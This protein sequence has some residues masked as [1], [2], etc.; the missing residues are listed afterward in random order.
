MSTSMACRT[1]PGVP[2]ERTRSPPWLPKDIGPF[3]PQSLFQPAQRLES[4]FVPLFVHVLEQIPKN[5]VG[6]ASGSLLIEAF[7]DPSRPE[8][9]PN[10]AP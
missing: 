8:S 4:H 9:S 7:R 2:G 6:E 5:G 1:P 3:D 10:C